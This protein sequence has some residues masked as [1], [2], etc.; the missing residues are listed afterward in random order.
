MRG[1]KFEVT[2][3]EKIFLEKEAQGVGELYRTSVGLSRRGK[4]DL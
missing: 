2:L 4:F 1:V 3:N